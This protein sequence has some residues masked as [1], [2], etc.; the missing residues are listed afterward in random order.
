MAGSSS[1][2][3]QLD[4]GALILVALVGYYLFFVFFPSGSRARA[5]PKHILCMQHLKAISWAMELYS[6]EHQGHIPPS[7]AALLEPHL[8]GDRYAIRCAECDEEYTYVLR[9]FAEQLKD[10]SHAGR[11]ICACCPK[12]HDM[13]RYP[14]KRYGR[15]ARACLFADGHV[16]LV[17]E[18]NVPALLQPYQ[19]TSDKPGRPD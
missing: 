16:E 8:D 10:L 19:G 9:G 5:G 1:L 15:W 4:I 12:A 14:D 18:D 13:S 11:Q 7:L 3:R 6:L 2:R 17:T